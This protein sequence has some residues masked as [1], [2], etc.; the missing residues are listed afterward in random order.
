MTQIRHGATLS[1]DSARHHLACRVQRSL[2][3]RSTCCCWQCVSHLSSQ[4]QLTPPG[5]FAVLQASERKSIA[6]SLYSC[7]DDLRLTREQ[8]YSTKHSLDEAYANVASC[9]FRLSEAAAEAVG[10]AE[11]LTETRAE[12][13][14]FQQ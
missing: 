7:R 12:L 11:V 2:T 6:T 3:L 5:P 14:N 1:Q 13:V 10:E 8:L 4:P 9:E